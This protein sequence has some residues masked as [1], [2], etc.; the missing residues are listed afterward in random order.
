MGFGD[1]Y[2]GFTVTG[3]AA[4]FVGTFLVAMTGG[5]GEGGAAKMF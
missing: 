5:D 2:C 4:G 3:L 1:C